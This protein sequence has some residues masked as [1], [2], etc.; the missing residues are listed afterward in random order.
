VTLCRD[1]S[2][3]DARRDGCIPAFAD[4]EFAFRSMLVQPYFD[5]GPK[6]PF[7]KRFKEVAVGFNAP[8]TPQ[9]QDFKAE[10]DEG[11]SR[12]QSGISGDEVCIGT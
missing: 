3:S 7:L 2:I 6:F 12:Y 4:P 11:A 8:E 5:H 10:D 1:H 9:D